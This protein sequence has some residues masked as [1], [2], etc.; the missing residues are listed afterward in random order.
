MEAAQAEASRPA[1]ARSADGGGRHQLRPRRSTRKEHVLYELLIGFL[2]GLVAGYAA[3]GVLTRD[4]VPIGRETGPGPGSGPG[5]PRGKPAPL[6]AGPGLSP[7]ASPFP[8]H[9]VCPA[10]HGILGAGTKSVQPGAAPGGFCRPRS[11]PIGQSVGLA[12]DRAPILRKRPAP[13][14][15]SFRYRSGVRRNRPPVSK[16]G[17][18]LAHSSRVREV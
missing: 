13:A 9:T 7:H 11:W 16:P 18:V 10:L 4:Q 3:V 1:R 15:V 12:R 2:P 6:G 8:R 17:T 5:I 14:S